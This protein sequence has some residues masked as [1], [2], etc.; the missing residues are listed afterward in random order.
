MLGDLEADAQTADRSVL[1]LSPRGAATPK[2]AVA[3]AIGVLDRAPEDDVPWMLDR[4][5]AA[6]SETALVA[7]AWNDRRPGR[8]A[9][10][11]ALPKIW[12]RQQMEAAARRTPGRRWRLVYHRSGA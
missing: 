11:A 3:A 8:Q 10:A 5:F 2:A 4:L 6:A 7:A 1:A 9:A 12:W